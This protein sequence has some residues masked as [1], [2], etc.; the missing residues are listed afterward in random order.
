[1][2][3]THLKT[4]AFFCVLLLGALHT[5]AQQFDA[6]SAAELTKKN[7]AAIG[8]SQ[9]D[10]A[11]SRVSDAYIDKV[12]GAT[13]V[14]LQQTY[15]GIDVFNSIQTLAFR[16]D[17]LVAKSGN[18]I[19]QIEAMINTKE[20][21]ASLAAM[22][23]VKAAAI[24]LKLSPAFSRAA[25]QITPQL[26]E[27]GDLGI[28][29]VN[30]KSKLIW[31]PDE[32]SHTA[33]L[34]WQVELQP[35][36]SA[37]YWLVNVDAKK[38]NVIS[39]INLNIA[40]DWTHAKNPYKVNDVLAFKDITTADALSSLNVNSARYR[41]IPFPAESPIHPGGAPAVKQNPWQLAGAGNDATILQWN[42]NGITTFDST[43]GN[44]VLAQEDRNGNNGS[45]RG[46]VSRTPLPDL[47]FTFNPNFSKPP[48]TNVNQRFAITNLF[49]WNNIM[50]DISYQYGFDEAAGNFQDNNLG[51]GGAG[52]DYVFADAQDGSGTNNAN[53]STPPDGSNPRMQMFLFNAVPTFIVNQPSSI[54]GSKVSTESDFSTKNKIADKGTITANVVLY[55][56]NASGSTH[57]AC[58]PAANPGALSGKIALIDRG[59]CGFTDKVK[60]AQNAGAIAAIVVDNVP[61]E[62]PIIMG[63][64]DNTITIPAVMVSFETGD[65]MK[66]VLNSGTLNVTLKTGVQLDGD[67]DNGVVS[68]EYTH[69]ISN[70]LTGG[71]SNTSCLNNKEQMGEG[72][73]DYMALMVTTDWSKATVN[74]GPKARPMGTYVLGQGTDGP[75]IRYYPYSTDM[76]VNPWTYDSMKLSTRF[77]NNLFLWDPHVVG[78]VWCNMLW[79][80]TWEI[81]KQSGIKPNI[82]RARANGG[83][84][85]ALNLVITGMKL[86][87]CSPGFVDGRDAILKADTLLYGGVHSKAIWHAFASRGLGVNASQGSSNNIKDG[88][89]D[90]T[91]PS[92]ALIASDN[93]DAVK[94]NE[95]ALLQW[96][97]INQKGIREFVIERSID[98]Q[99]FNKI[100]TVSANTSS[101]AYNFTDHLPVTGV[102]YYRLQSSVNGKTVYSDVRGVNF[103][104]IAITPNPAKDKVNITVGGNTKLL[105]VIITNATGQHIISYDMSGE[106]LQAR[107]PHVA[108]G[109]YYIKIT[110]DGFSETRKLVIQ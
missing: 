28:S 32:T 35:K 69:G 79:N 55:N 62:Y 27:F 57:E 41:V 65:T 40:C 22:D 106:S 29:S 87:P 68:H 100:G 43:R 59:T 95:S 12:S 63:G 108:P 5:M 19:P 56:D 97:N 78:E 83:N 36:G 94:Q 51:R 15:K 92:S 17:K 46:A 86:Q 71:P 110:G 102:N 39:K 37:D 30:I 66:Q 64:T 4:T 7:A 45:G 13:M 85:I 101:D 72:W 50:H 104:S 49:Y 23:A 42:S 103:N 109:M 70:R 47:T 38:G 33:V 9:T 31:L 60:N 2:K 89:A 21:K 73:S 1:M 14:Y 11:N 98:G 3:S 24:H 44:N 18:R 61:G 25:R 77:S 99:N 96:Q 10:I 53:F 105:K 54:S 20:A 81:I 80:M 82:Y 90:Y 91:E 52:D 74:D 48:T 34:S 8:L 58:S 75:G 26:F 88:V 93:F 67:I 76:S 16:N 6:K 107:L 84:I